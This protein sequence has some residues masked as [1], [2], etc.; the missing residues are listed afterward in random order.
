MSKDW[1]IDELNEPIKKEI[2]LRNESPHEF[3]KTVI[4]ERRYLFPGNHIVVIPR[5]RWMTAHESSGGHRLFSDGGVCHFVCAG[6]LAVSWTV[7][8]GEP[9]FSH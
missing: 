4:Q 6:W 3:V 7:A 8:D 5:V 9:H 1:P 2:K